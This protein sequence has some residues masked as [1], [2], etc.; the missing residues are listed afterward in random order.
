MT[1]L[2]HVISMDV[3]G[4]SVKSGVVHIGTDIVEQRMQTPME[5]KG[6]ADSILSTLAGIVNLHSHS[7]KNGDLAG[8][9]LAFP[10]PFD[11]EAGISRIR[12]LEKFD[13]LFE[14]N[15][16][17][18]LRKRID[19]G[20][21]PIRFRNDAEAAIVG[22][23]LFGIGQG[24]ARVI[25][26]T[27]GTGFGSAFMLDGIPQ[28]SG[29]GVPP[30]GWLHPF[31]VGDVRADDF[32]SIRGLQRLLHEAGCPLTDPPMAT[33]SAR[34]GNENVKAVFSAYGERLGAFL[35]AFIEGYGA[36]AVIV[37]GGIAAAWDLFGP[38]LR[39]VITVPILPG[40]RGMDAAILGAAQLLT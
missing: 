37:L 29:D 8:V 38:S 12:G 9:A 24:Y 17:V 32:F 6:T 11:Y 36:D 28:R 25:G 16:G 20:S 2:V 33:E 14:I 30:N 10:G 1:P 3:G 4:T 23:C 31:P 34:A 40:S 18:E 7:T 27:L 5:S 15:V 26:V 35:S 22:E 19:I 13:S 39:T 21:R